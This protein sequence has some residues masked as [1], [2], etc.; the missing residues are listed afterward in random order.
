MNAVD[1]L[2]A[3][4]DRS[5]VLRIYTEEVEGNLVQVVVQD[6][7]KG[8]KPGE[9]ERI[10]EPFHTTKQHGLGMGLGISRSIVEAHGGH[11]WATQDERDGQGAAFQFTLPISEVCG[12]E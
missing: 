6:S 9:A 5:R 4:S 2:S 11:L 8:I 1:S 10:F 3:V 12:D 7:G